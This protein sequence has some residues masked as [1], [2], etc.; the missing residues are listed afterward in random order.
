MKGT[1]LLRLAWIWHHFSEQPSLEAS[2][3]SERNTTKIHRHRNI[4]KS[5]K[6]NCYTT[7]NHKKGSAKYNVESTIKLKINNDKLII[8]KEVKDDNRETTKRRIKVK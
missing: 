7:N 1:F 5:I 3:P 2:F 6:N 4:I 8:K